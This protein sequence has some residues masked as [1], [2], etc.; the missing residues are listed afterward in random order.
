MCLT[1]INKKKYFI[2]PKAAASSLSLPYTVK[3][4]AV[5]LTRSQ[6]CLAMIEI[7]MIVAEET[8]TSAPS[9]G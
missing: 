5:S 6:G 9:I 3:L 8:L 2:H 1:K 7:E 4:K